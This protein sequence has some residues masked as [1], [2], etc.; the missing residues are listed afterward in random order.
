VK[1]KPENVDYYRDGD[2]W[3]ASVAKGGDGFFVHHAGEE[4]WTHVMPGSLYWDSLHQNL[5]RTFHD[6]ESCRPGDEKGLPPLPQ[7]PPIKH[8]A[9]RD[10][11]LPEHNLSAASYPALAARLASLPEHML[12]VWI[13][14]EEDWYETTAGDGCFR[15]FTNQV[16]SSFAQAQVAAASPQSGYTNTIATVVIGLDGNNIVP[17]LFEPGVFDHYEF[18]KVVRQAEASLGLV[19]KPLPANG[20]EKN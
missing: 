18:E 2:R 14:L 15:Y 5:Y 4:S 13:V 10:N 20:L 9:W 7:V 1:S 3:V 17:A 8:V 16:Y 19:E 11:F 12:Q 6:Y